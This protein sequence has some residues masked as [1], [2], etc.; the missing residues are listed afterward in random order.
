MNV[1]K[2]RQKEIIDNLKIQIIQKDKEIHYLQERI[3]SLR[4]VPKLKKD[5]MTAH[6]QSV[7]IENENETSI[8]EEM[9]PYEQNSERKKLN[10]PLSPEY[11]VEKYR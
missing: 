8:V 2:Q 11:K 4:K 10:Q 1:D 3:D 7:I 6:S 9:Q 5:K